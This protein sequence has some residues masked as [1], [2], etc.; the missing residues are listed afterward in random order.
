MR[1]LIFVKCIFN[2]KRDIMH[3]ILHLYCNL[4]PN[5]IKNETQELALNVYYES[6]FSDSKIY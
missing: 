5:R 3:I 6:G 2:A 1:K 4:N